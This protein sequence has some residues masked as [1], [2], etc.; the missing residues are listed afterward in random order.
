[1]AK[2][3][4]QEKYNTG[5]TVIDGQ[6]KRILKYI[7]DLQEACDNGRPRKTVEKILI[8]LVEYTTT[9]FAFEESLL[10]DSK[11][12]KIKE[13]VRSHELFEKKLSELEKKYKS[14][15]DVAVLL[16]QLLSKWLFEHI[17]IEDSQYVNSINDFFLK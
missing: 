11:Y 15:E 7:N 14:G 1:M 6:H 5:I 8:K 4:W 3:E 13:H 10:T 12:D 2:I 17:L 16:I 9:H